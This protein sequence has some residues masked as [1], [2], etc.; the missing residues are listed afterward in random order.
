MEAHLISKDLFDHV[1]G[2]LTRPTGPPNSVKSFDRKT[3]LAYAELVKHLDPSQYPYADSKNPVVIWNTLQTIHMA[4]GFSSR[5]ALMRNFINSRFAD[6]QPMTNWI[7]EI[8]RQAN[9]LK[10]LGADITDQWVVLIL[11]NGLPDRFSPVVHA[12]DSIDTKQLTL[13]VVINRLLNAEVANRE[14]LKVEAVD[15]S[16]A[17]AMAAKAKFRNWKNQQSEGPP[18]CHK[19]RGFGHFRRDC[20][21]GQAKLSHFNDTDSVS[22][23]PDEYAF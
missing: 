12:L 17:A 22:E 6:G 23:H 15:S 16:E 5:Q 8:R 18:Q 20:P 3:Q 10:T 11:T 7:S 2:S 13:D 21:N 9:E 4:R 1:N 14:V 19:C